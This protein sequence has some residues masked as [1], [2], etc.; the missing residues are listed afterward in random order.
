VPDGAPQD[1]AAADVDLCTHYSPPPV[2]PDDDPST[3]IDPPLTFVVDAL[4]ATPDGGLAGYDLDDD[5]T[6]FPG[7]PT[8]HEGQGS[9]TPPAGTACDLDGGVDNALGQA[10]YGLNV[11]IRSLVQ[12]TLADNTNYVC[13]REGFL[14]QISE[15]NGKPNDSLVRVSPMLGAGVHQLHADGQDEARALDAG[16][17]DIVDGGPIPIHFDESDLWTIDKASLNPSGLDPLIQAQGYVKDGV[18]VVDRLESLR[19][20][21]GGASIDVTTALITARI[22]PIAGDGGRPRF[23]L[24]EGVITGRLATGPLL[25]SLAQIH[26]PLGPGLSD[27]DAGDFICATGGATTSAIYDAFKQLVCNGRDV[28]SNS[29]ADHLRLDGSALIPCD[30]ISIAVNFTAKPASVFD[31]GVLFR[32]PPGCAQLD[33]APFS[34]QCL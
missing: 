31:R 32:Y 27:P 20:F 1:D 17:G 8:R 10:L 15:Y 24:D 34:D 29:S 14:L 16:C 19:I 26:I 13:G 22:L 30:S 9:C 25:S 18:L 12:K 21:L 23:A 3:V 7:R 5:C 11:T 28:V 33:G 2:G 6:C 4:S